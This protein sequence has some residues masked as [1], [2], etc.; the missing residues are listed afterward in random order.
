M[1]NE[2]LKILDS[3]FRLLISNFRT[4]M[5]KDLIRFGLPA[6]STVRPRELP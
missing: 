6:R 3:A 4:H 2:E 5:K 1:K